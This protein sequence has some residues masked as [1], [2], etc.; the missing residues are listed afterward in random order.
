MGAKMKL[1]FE[2]WRKYVN[3]AGDPDSG[4][5]NSP[6]PK[7]IA[8]ALER[9]TIEKTIEDFSFNS[10]QSSQ[11]RWGKGRPIIDYRFNEDSGTWIYTATIPDDPNNSDNWE[12]INSE[13]GEDLEAFLTR[14][15]ELPK[16]QELSLP[17]PEPSEPPFRGPDPETHRRLRQGQ[18]ELGGYNRRGWKPRE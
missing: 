3:E 7:A 10:G 12:D 1:L 11:H 17:E 18:R 6:E 15:E 9:S 16:Q 14:V 5:D 13:G 8:M 2:D 4:A